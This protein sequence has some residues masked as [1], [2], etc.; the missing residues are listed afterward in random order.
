MLNTK[1]VLD[2]YF[3]INKQIYIAFPLFED[4]KR[5]CLRYNF[6]NLFPISVFSE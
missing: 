2:Y 6:R 4:G 1:N 3:N 5:K